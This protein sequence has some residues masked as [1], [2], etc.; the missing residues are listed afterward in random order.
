[1]E[2]ELELIR[3]HQ[4]ESW[5][6]FSS[7]W[8]KWDKINMDFIR[9]MGEEIVRM[10]DLKSSDYVLDVAGGTGEQ[11]LTIASVL[12]EGK[13]IITDLSPQMLEI[14]SEKAGQLGIANVEMLS[15]DVS[16]L[17]FA[18]NSFDAISCRFGFMFFPDLLLAAREMFRVLKPGGKIATTVWNIAEK[19]FWVT[20]IMQ[21]I[22]RNL[23]LPAPKP[24]APGMFRCASRDLL[25]GLFQQAGLKNLEVKEVTG[26]LDCKTA[27]T[28][29]EMMTEV[30]AP[31]AAALGKT[32]AVMREKI[33]KEV[34]ELLNNKYPEG[35][36]AIS[37]SA[38]LVYA[39]K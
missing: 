10:L 8:K 34:S 1:M 23:D 3:D 31:I 15:C 24:G 11:G 35:E 38:L 16:Q 19:N 17:P 4:K 20:A 5:S 2:K 13:V 32:D 28:Y 25:P 27:E 39:E 26:T 33:K 36:I 12:K 9:P 29:W 14:A 37:A 6:K 22:N 7:G 18:D 21:T 30:G